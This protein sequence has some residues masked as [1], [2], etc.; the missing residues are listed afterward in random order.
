MIAA[1][2]AR[3]WHIAGAE[4]MLSVCDLTGRVVWRVGQPVGDEIVVNVADWAKGMY[5]VR[6]GC[7]TL[8]FVKE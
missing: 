2:A 1:N 3:R 6:S 5:F 7:H 4:G 8:K